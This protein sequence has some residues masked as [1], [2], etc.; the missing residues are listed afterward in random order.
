MAQLDPDSYQGT[1][2]GSGQGAMVAGMATGAGNNASTAA[3]VLVI[4]CL[5]GLAA[6]RHS[7]RRF[8]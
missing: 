1:K 3:G 8:L 4:I 6:V 7:F 5:V 2:A